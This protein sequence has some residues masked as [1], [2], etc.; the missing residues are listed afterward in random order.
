[1]KFWI[2]RDKDGGYGENRVYFWKVNKSPQKNILDNTITFQDTDTLKENRII[3]IL[4]E[5]FDL[6]YG[7]S[8]KPGTCERYN[9]PRINKV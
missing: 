2:S 9:I 6:L 3:A 4:I 8:P 1:M 5:E 7:F